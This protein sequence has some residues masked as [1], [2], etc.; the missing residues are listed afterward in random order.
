MSKIHVLDSKTYNKIAAGEVVERPSSVVKELLENS[1]DAG[2]TNITVEIENGGI[3]LIK[4][5]DNGCG[6][7]KEDLVFALT[8]HA[9]SKIEDISD[10]ENVLTLGFRGEAL[11]SIASVSRLKI[12]SST[13]GINGAYIYTEGGLDTVV[14]DCPFIKG[15]EICVDELF[16][17]VPARRKFLKTER[18]EEAEITNIITRFILGYSDISFKY[19]VDG[20]V[21]LQSFG[22]G[23]ENAMVAIYGAKIISDCFFVDTLKNGIKVVGYLGKHY[24]T[25]GKR[26]YQSLFING[27]YVVN[28]TTSTAIM[29]AYSSYIMKRQYPFYVLKVYLPSEVVD[30][31]VHPQKSDVRFSNNQIVYSALYKIVK[32][33][34]DGTNTPI[35]LSG[36]KVVNIEEDLLSSNENTVK[37]TENSTSDLPFKVNSDGEVI[38]SFNTPNK[39]ILDDMALFDKE[40]DNDNKTASAFL[41]KK[42]DEFK[43]NSKKIEDIFAENKAYLESLEKKNSFTKTEEFKPVLEKKQ[44]FVQ[45]KINT[46]ITLK[47]IG[48]ALKTYLILEDGE[49]VYFI[50]QHAAHERILYDRLLSKLNEQKSTMQLLVPYT[51]TLTTLEAD[52]LQKKLQ[53]IQ[54]IGIEIEEFGINT[55]KVSSLPI[56]LADMDLQEFFDDI[57]GD[58]TNLSDDKLPE[59]ITDKIAQKACKSAIKSGNGLSQMEVDALLKDINGNLGLKCPHGRPVVVKITRTEIDKWF[60]RIL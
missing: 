1:I 58:M 9:T 40:F 52:F 17:N 2:A 27:R 14:N 59:V 5:T 20:K 37:N 34:L 47:F 13:D 30:V 38:S 7:E 57:L 43:N 39:A 19:I 35:E 32:D 11:A 54:K 60:K 53:F 22:D 8:A 4:I 56:D 24:F 41:D 50:D 51:F 12:T 28:N 55:F 10:I 16:F 18:S 3:S 21:L 46:D 45:E 49:N 44:E 33:V 6:V 29:N 31:N 36:E 26:S 15:T 42:E 23:F 48:Q 25:K